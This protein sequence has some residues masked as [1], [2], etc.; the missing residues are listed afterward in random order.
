[1]IQRNSSESVDF[2]LGAIYV[3]PSGSRHMVSGFERRTHLRHSPDYRQVK[4]TISFKR[5]RNRAMCVRD[6]GDSE[7]AAGEGDP[8]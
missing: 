1:M 3:G 2:S 8:I 5:R 4:R 6:G 7:S